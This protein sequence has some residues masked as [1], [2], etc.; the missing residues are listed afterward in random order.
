MLFMLKECEKE[1]FTDVATGLSIRQVLLEEVKTIK[2]VLH[3]A[4]VVL[5]ASFAN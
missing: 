5:A 4:G 3:M 2:I 1:Y